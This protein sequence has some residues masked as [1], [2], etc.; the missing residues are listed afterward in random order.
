MEKKRTAKICSKPIAETPAVVGA[1]VVAGTVV[2][3]AVVLVVLSSAATKVRA[4][5]AMMKRA[6]ILEN[7]FLRGLEV[8]VFYI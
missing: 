2:G 1:A 7:I 6:R 3:A 4:I 5:K 8:G